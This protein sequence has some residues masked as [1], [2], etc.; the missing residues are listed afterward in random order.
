MIV[1]KVVSCTVRTVKKG[2]KMKKKLV[3]YFA[4]VEQKY[5]EIRNVVKC[6]IDDVQTKV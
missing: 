3:I 4:V 5:S 6:L 1:K 2:E